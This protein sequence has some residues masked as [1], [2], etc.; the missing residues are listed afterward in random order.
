MRRSSTALACCCFLTLCA[1]GS[2]SA[3]EFAGARMQRAVKETLTGTWVAP[4]GSSYLTLTLSAE[5]RFS[6]DGLTGDYVV[7]GNN[8][9]LSTDTGEVTYQF[10]GDKNQLTLSG[11]D[12][13]QTLKF[14][15]QPEAAASLQWLFDLSPENV[16]RKLYRVLTILGVVLIC[17]LIIAALRAVS[18]LAIYSNWGPLRL[19]YRYHKNRALTVHSLV[20]NGVK[21]VVYFTAL[22]F[23]L[24]ELGVNYTAYLAS[25]SVIGLAIG[26]GSQGLVQDV[27]TGFFV[28][29]EG[30]FDVGDMVEISGQVGVVQ[31]LGLRMT[32][33]RNYLGEMIVIPN[34]NIAVVGNFTRG[35]QHA[36]IDVTAASRQAAEQEVK[37]LRQSAGEVARQFE[38][39]IIG[40]PRMSGVISLDTGEHFV[41]MKLAFWPQQQWVI[42]QQLVPRIREVLKAAGIEVPADRIVVF[43][44]ERQEQKAPL[45]AGSLERLRSLFSG[46]APSRGGASNGS[47]TK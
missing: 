19:F 24:G 28:I 27:V 30:Q 42:E 44:H 18:R 4:V 37:L 16:T 13:P 11:G 22:G 5:G 25:L 45:G 8:L 34:R 33:L 9:K 12:L 40:P 14:S 26:F 39:V 31:E 20:L 38:G 35:A 21:Y 15:R 43:Y 6:L 2:A 36:R 32:K 7:E 46:R 23:V 1:A 29:F 41:R 10:D 17:R 3:A 47:G